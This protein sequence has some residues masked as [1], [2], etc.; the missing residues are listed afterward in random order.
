MKKQYSIITGAANG[1]GK[2]FANELAKR[3]I[4]TLLIDLPD[5]G[6][7]DLCK[8]IRKRTGT[9]SVCFE[10]DLTIKDNIIK[11]TEEINKKYDVFMLINNVGTGGAKRFDKVDVDY[12]N[13]MIQ[14]NIM[15]TSVMTHQLIPNLK[16][17]D[18][19]Y[20]LNI[21]SMA[22][23]S[24]MGYKTV[25]PASKAF[26]QYFS[27]GLCQEFRK[28]NIFVSVVFPGPMKTNADTIRRIE[29]QTAIGKFGLQSPEKV[30]EKAIRRLFKR[31]TVIIA[32]F[33]NRLNW[34][35]MKIIPSCIRL[36]LLSKA[37]KEEAE[38]KDE[39]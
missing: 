21:S 37:M 35:L 1:L 6:L 19:S 22:A 20:I 4:N 7:S 38:M 32:N 11:L 24:P 9:D 29:N 3:K 33:A 18:K 12:I 25:Y 10:Q 31:D 17:Q 39:L 28:T 30:A 15:A 26:I 14:L 2:A 5:T 34:M 8:E 13:R 36:P 23:F 16:K 27:R